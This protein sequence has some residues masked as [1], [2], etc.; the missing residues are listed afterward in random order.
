MGSS[1]ILKLLNVTHYYRNRKSKKWYQPFGYD[2]EDIELNNINLHIYQGEALGIIGE[3]DSSK[4]LIGRLLSGEIKPDKG[5]VV[6]KTD[7]FFADIEDK[8][9]LSLSVND[10]V[11][12]AII[13][14]QYDT[15][16][17]K[18]EQIIKFSH[19][20]NETN[21]PI[22]SLTDQQ[23]AQLQFTL[24]R[25]SK[26]NIIIMNQILHNLD[27]SYF[28]KAIELTDEY[29]NNNLTIVMID[30]NVERISKASNYLAWIS[31]GQ[32][33]MEGS[34]K[35]VLP[36]FKEHE[37]DRQ[38][39][40]SEEEKANFDVDWKKNRTRI[41]ELTYNFRRIERYKHAKPPV[42]LVRFWTLFTIFFMG[43][44]FMALLMFN[45]LG[46]LEIGEN[47]DQASIQNQQKNPYE[48]KLAYGIVLNDAV[49]LEN[50]NNSKK[51]NADQYSFVTITGENSKNYRVVVDN[52][53][54]KIAKNKL[55]YFDP[56]GLFEEHSL[57]SLAP[58]M[59]TNYSNY[60]EF[61]NSHLHKK[62]NKVTDSLVPESG[63]DNRFNVPI[64]QQPIS[65]IF[66]DQ[67]KLTG[68]TFPIKDKKEL[69]DKFD[70]ENNFW[71][72]KSGDGYFMA[73]LK[74]NKWIYI[75]L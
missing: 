2:A 25:T 35:Q 24:A 71:I 55:R 47:Q 26:A 52:N 31:H 46:K 13:L 34:I 45:D 37:K 56:A 33:R 70:I 65:M 68:F 16:E 27:E 58:Y 69:K 9:L 61:F 43:L 29:I 15:S 21:E 54:Y 20:D 36:M 3:V 74:N 4:S 17:H 10:Y 14:F 38:S 64:V 50:M 30:D 63:K 23:F 1:I 72:T 49:N 41:P 42:A 44:L 60:N 39:L 59:H 75:E 57:K 12:N 40:N 67:N 66:D 32:L 51:I 8:P 53:N 48:E 11:K 73:D 62:H 7:M 28:E 22:N 5:R 18:V 6:R 19:L